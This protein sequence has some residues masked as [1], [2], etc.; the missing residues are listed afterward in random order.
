ML[1]APFTRQQALHA[2]ITLAQLRHPRWMSRFRGVYEKPD[3]NADLVTICQALSLAL[4]DDAVFSGLTAAALR[5]WWMPHRAPERPLHVTVPPYRLLERN[6]VRCIRSALSPDDVEEV[7]GLRVTTGLRTLQD[8]AA[9]WSLIDL[10]V[11][12][13]S[14]LRQRDCQSAK[15]VLENCVPGRR[16]V[17][18]LRR[19]MSLTDARSESAME[20]V[21]RLTLVIPGLPPPEPQAILRDQWGGWLARVDLLGA[22]GMSVFEFDGANHDEPE[23]HAEDT[24]RWRMLHRHGFQV[25]PYTKRDIFSGGLQIIDDYE[26]ALGLSPDPNRAQAWLREWERSSFGRRR[27]ALRRRD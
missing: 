15:W 25:Y 8:L 7:A 13:D 20:T 12:A 22:D 18:T 16:G 21:L 2:G 6:D 23:R 9:Q 27:S 5:G 26:T 10:V 19:T 24:S 17:R 4:P 14:A 11:M 3:A 1:E